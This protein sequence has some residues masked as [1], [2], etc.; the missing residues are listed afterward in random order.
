M[1]MEAGLCLYGSDID[2]STKPVES[3]LAWLVGTY[4]CFLFVSLKLSQTE[5]T[6]PFS[7]KRRRAE[8]NFPGAAD[9]LDQ[10]KNGSKQRRVGIKMANGPP[11][12]HGAEIFKDGKRIGTVTSGCPSPS[13]G[14]NIAMGFVLDEFK[15]V[16]QQVELNIRNKMYSAEIAKMPFIKTN[17]YSDKK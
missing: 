9:V 6:F 12:R 2:E 3:G 1:R 13:I 8:A 11:A 5:S 10:L 17:Y 15:G 16:G 14:G 7:A 4:R